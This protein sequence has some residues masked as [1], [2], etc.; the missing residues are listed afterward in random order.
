M[1]TTYHYVVLRLAADRL[2]GEVINVG[3]AIWHG[4][5]PVR[6]MTL[7]T[8]N[9]LRAIDATWDTARLLKWSHNIELICSMYRGAREQIAALASFG[10]CIENAVGMFT[11]DTEAQLA[12]KITAIKTTYISNRA[13]AEKPKRE[14][15]P[16]LQT[17]LRDQFERMQVLGHAVDDVANH[18]VVPN[19]PVPAHPDLKN[20]FV[21]KNGVYRITQ[22]IDYH[23]SADS[24]HQKLQEACVKSTAA[25]L[26]L[27]QYGPDTQ[28]YAVV[29]I[30]EAFQEASDTH[31]DLLL[32][33]GFEVFHFNQPS[34]MERYLRMATPAATH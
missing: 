31:I 21:Y 13:R 28:R 20:D 3:I 2:R 18:L 25:E 19:L 1:N 30:P 23:V 29:D 8:L 32:A 17:A 5:E 6:V 4:D 22:T 12:E 14:K 27:R 15:R 33:Q 26:S 10:F 34:D 7:A 16:R 11:A 24:L 9:K